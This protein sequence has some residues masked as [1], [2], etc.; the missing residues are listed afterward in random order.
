MAT[1]EEVFEALKPVM[2]PEHPVS[3]TDPQMGIVKPEYI[4]VDDNL[5][6]VRFKPTVPHC[7]MG[8]FIGI[9]IRHRLE[10]MFPESVIQVKLLPGTHTLEEDVNAM[11]GDDSKYKGIVDQLKSRGM[12]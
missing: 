12:L 5:I 4:R 10:E 11:I 8:G 7:P 6:R 1:V 9:M 2:D 3:I